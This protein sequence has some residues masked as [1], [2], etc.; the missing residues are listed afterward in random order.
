M[1]DWNMKPERFQ[2]GLA[3]T[4]LVC[5]AALSACSSGSSTATSGTSGGATPNS[6][7]GLSTK[8]AA[9][10]AVPTFTAPGPAFDARAAAAGK[11]IA[12][13]P[14][15]SSIPFVQTIAQGM[16]AAG[17][18]IG[19]GVTVLQNQGQ[20]S[21]WAQAMGSA[22]AQK[23]KSI[24]LLAGLDP[25]LIGPQIGEAK[26]AGVGAVA[27]HFYGVGQAP[28]PGLA[29]TVDAPYGTAGE[30][31]ADY[32]IGKTG[33]K[34]N[35]LVVTINQVLSTRPMVDGIKK[36]VAH[37][38]AS[39]C[40]LTYTNTSIAGLASEVPANV[41][42]ALQ[43][44]PDINYVVA[45]YDSAEVPYVLSGLQ[46]AGAAGKVKIVTFNGTPS[47]LKLVADGQVEMD[48]GEDLNWISLAILDQHLRL[49]AG[50]PAVRNEH[51]PLRIWD[52]SNVAEVGSP[53]RNSV[54]YGASYVDGYQKL[55]KLPAGVSLS[56]LG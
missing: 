28:T 41:R 10:S 19:L 48:I 7:A 2:R 23:V 15:S 47:V 54:G 13:I 56:G 18:R 4:A 24:D 40:Q 36:E 9:N 52:K 27:S 6:P 49:L 3:V 14:A 50:L 25:A 30:L 29:A 32:A 44:N 45:L 26:A 16:Q 46:S 17:S 35:M 39:T 53:P 43:R 55:W 51:L 33:G 34:L 20:T 37:Y 5:C 21:Q 38:C 42:G 22:V 12:V 1:R 11:S 31:L 8:L